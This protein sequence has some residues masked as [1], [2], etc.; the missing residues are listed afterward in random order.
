M[1]SLTFNQLQLRVLFLLFILFTSALIGYRYFIELP[2]LERSISLLAERELDILTFSIENMLNAASRTNYDY[3][4]WTS[5]YDF[6]LNE[7]Q[8]YL[9]ENLVDN[10]FKSL[11]IDGIYFINEKLEFIYGKGLHHLTGNTLD[12]SFYDFDKYPANLSMLPI[13]TI[14]K[15]APTKSGFFMTKNGPAIY[16]VNQVRTSNVD[17]ENRGFFISIRLIE[18]NFTE[19]LS[20]YTLTKVSFVPIQSDKLAKR[21]T[22]SKKASVLGVKPFTK[23]LISELA[24]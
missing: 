7:N 8:D 10:T 1:K 19:N 17:G 11:E 23:V 21:E 4:V 9:D 20:K 24:M 22:W 16:S 3:A 12:F 6:M 14:D 2:K 5:T 13:P 18:N 15:K